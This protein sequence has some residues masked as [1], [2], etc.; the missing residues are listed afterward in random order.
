MLTTV[1]T[2]TL[3]A[4]AVTGW[5]TDGV[6]VA[7]GRTRVPS[8]A[9][10]GAGGV[11]IGWGDENH[12][13]TH[14]SDAYGMRLLATGLKHPLWPVLGSPIAAEPAPLDE[15][16]YLVAPGSDGSAYWLWSQRI[17]EQDLMLKRTLADGALDPGWPMGGV[18]VLSSPM[19]P[20][21]A[22]L[23]PDGSGGVYIAWSEE[24]LGAPG[25]SLRFVRGQHILADGSPAPGWPV[26]GIVIWSA[27]PGPTAPEVISD[28]AGGAYFKANM[29]ST[30]VGQFT[31]VQHI[32][33]S[34]SVAPGWPAGGLRACTF[35]SIQY[36]PDHGFVLDGAGGVYVAW[37]DM[38]DMPPGTTT[39]MGDAY[40]TR[41]H[42]DGTR[43]AGFPDTGLP[44]QT[45]PGAQWY[46]RLCQDG[47]GGAVAVWSDYAI[48][49]PRLTRITASGTQAPGWPAGGTIMC[50]APG[51]PDHPRV[52][53]DA[54]G[55]A[56]AAW[57]QGPDE[58]VHTQHFRGDGALAAGWT[59]AGRALVDILASSQNS[60]SIH[61][62]EPGN[63]IVVWQDSRQA[64][65]PRGSIR[66][67]K[68]VTDGLVPTQ[69]ALQSA[70]ADA[71]RVRLTWW[72]VGAAEATLTVERSSDGEVWR[73]LGAVIAESSE[74]VTYEDRDIQPGE[75]L[76][77]RLV[78]GSGR[79]LVAAAWVQVPQRLE[80]A[81]AGARPNPARL[82]AL[83]VELSLAAQGS[84]TLELIDLAG[85]RVAWRDLASLAPGRHTIPFPETASLAPG[86]HWLRLRQGAAVRTTGVVLTR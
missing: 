62:A 4:T 46:P 8:A 65:R 48:G 16:Q 64:D 29:F 80:F 83:T 21:E 77:Y 42:A 79:V 43:A 86:M 11:F 1:L 38:R 6:P 69:L 56:Y 71:E 12:Y 57:S 15:G 72:G 81:L 44:L 58:R 82:G 70:E 26:G 3:L 55:G 30:G 10:D 35:Q 7:T 67:Q 45:A 14:Y 23:S 33:A 75:R 68:L 17:H 22:S 78:D 66:A 47:A 60:I 73:V 32:L 37:D 2:A 53:P 52:V 18:D 40:I 5:V 59:L 41:I 63:A 31:L 61:P 34:G 24:T 49:Q 39:L 36:S 28:G 51:Y 25:Y 9:A 50:T 13:D 27:N 54:T 76:A 84:G 74:Q 20:T 85:R 19:E